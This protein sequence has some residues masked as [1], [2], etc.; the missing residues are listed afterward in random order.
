MGV[1]DLQFRLLVV[2]LCEQLKALLNLD[3][4]VHNVPENEDTSGFVMEI[5]SLLKELGMLDISAS[6]D[7]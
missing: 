3:E 6:C 2:E 7:G 5:S 4:S 1:K